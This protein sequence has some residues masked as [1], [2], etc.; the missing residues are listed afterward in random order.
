MP[1]SIVGRVWLQV[2]LRAKR[3]VG[4]GPRSSGGAPGRPNM[5]L[6]DDQGGTALVAVVVDCGWLLWVGVGLAC[7]RG[8]SLAWCMVVVQSVTHAS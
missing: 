4:W 8:S 7:V 2:V 3:E 5:R 1:R 6:W